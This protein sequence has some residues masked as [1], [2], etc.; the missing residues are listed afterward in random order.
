VSLEFDGGQ[1]LTLDTVKTGR[2]QYFEIEPIQT[3]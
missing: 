1:V 2:P 3:T